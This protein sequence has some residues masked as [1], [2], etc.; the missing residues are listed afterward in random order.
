[1]NIP[2]VGSTSSVFSKIRTDLN[3]A[4]PEINI[5]LNITNPNTSRSTV[6]LGKTVWFRVKARL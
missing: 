1:M 5:R 3:E 2:P 6:F 4:N